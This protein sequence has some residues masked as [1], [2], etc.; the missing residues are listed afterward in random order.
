[1]TSARFLLST[2]AFCM[3]AACNGKDDTALTETGDPD[4]QEGLTYAFTTDEEVAVGFDM[5]TEA[6]PFVLMYQMFALWGVDET[7]SCPSYVDDGSSVTIT[8]DCTDAK[9]TVWGGNLSWSVTASGDTASIDFVYDGFSV[10]DGGQTIAVDGTQTMSCAAYDGTEC[11]S[12]DGL[13]TSAEVSISDATNSL[14][15]RLVDQVVSGDLS[16]VSMIAS[17]GTGEISVSGMAYMPPEGSTDMLGFSMSGDLQYDTCD[18]EPDS[19]TVELVGANTVTITADGASS[20]TGCSA[21]TSDDGG[22][23]D[24]CHN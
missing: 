21:W 18:L 19:G 6:G 1:M 23:G 5:A 2:T 13:T 10:D 17:T 11:T 15:F 22:S 3:L 8:G 14:S 9:G 4:T 12:V 16:T 24:A 7:S 20:C